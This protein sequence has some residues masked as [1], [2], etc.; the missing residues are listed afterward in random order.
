MLLSLFFKKTSDPIRGKLINMVTNEVVSLREREISIGRNKS[1]D[2]VLPYDTISRLHAVIA[3]RSKGFVIFDTFS[4]S[5]I[6]LN[7]KKIEKWAHL[8][9]GDE[10]NIGGIQYRLSEG[11][12]KFIKD[13][14]G[15]LGSPS[16]KLILGLL[17]ALNLIIMLLNL[18]PNGVFNEMIVVVYLGYIALQW[19][20]YLFASYILRLQNYEL[21][22]IAFT[23]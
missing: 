4:K 23:F 12:Y 9:S 10:L 20:Y 11:R 5:G 21:E 6:K 17:T 3:Y 15:A 7:G 22:M 19:C 1:C 2:I 8:H 14:S 18:Y 13:K 16:Y